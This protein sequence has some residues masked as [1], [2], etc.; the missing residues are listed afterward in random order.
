ME[1]VLE[2]FAWGW[3][4]YQTLLSRLFD[5]ASHAFE[6]TAVVGEECTILRA[7]ATL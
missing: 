5:I 6:K 1:D 4:S 2:V 7:T 3:E